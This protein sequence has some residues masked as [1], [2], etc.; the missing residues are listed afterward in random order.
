ML[1]VIRPGRAIGL[2]YR[3]ISA[4]GSIVLGISTLR[5]SGRR[6]IR[7]SRDFFSLKVLDTNHVISCVA[8]P[9]E[10]IDFDLEGGHPGSGCV[11]C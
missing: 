8:G 11:A 6:V 5:S 9:Y 1:D 3:D 2:A 4:S 10:F 7:Q